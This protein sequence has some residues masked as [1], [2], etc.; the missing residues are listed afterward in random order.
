VNDMDSSHRRIPTA[1]APTASSDAPMYEAAR[2]D[3]FLQLMFFQASDRTRTP[4]P[5]AARPVA[6]GDYVPLRHSTGEQGKGYNLPLPTVAAPVRIDS[7]ATEV[8]TDLRRVNA[9]TI[10]PDKTIVEANQAMIASRVRALFVADNAR[11][12][13]GIITST[14]ILGERPIKFAQER[15]FRHDEIVV[16]DIMTPSDRLEILDFSDVQGARV[17]D[18]IAT[19]R[20]AGRQHALAVEAVDEEGS[21][22]RTVRGI[23]SLTQIARQLGIPPQQAHD[24]ARTFAEIE[25]AISP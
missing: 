8:M 19:L 10:G 22:R 16:R 20:A 9:V 23:F 5:I 12:V 6:T 4:A 13:F 17:G 14:D 11:H 24:I 3:D 2:K 15:G 7:P 25:A 1:G 18:V 21:L